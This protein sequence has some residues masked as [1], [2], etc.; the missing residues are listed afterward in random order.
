MNVPR[1]WLVQ[2]LKAWFKAEHGTYTGVEFM[3]GRVL[4]INRPGGQRI[5][6]DIARKK[7]EL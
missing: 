6:V 5:N 2:V 3:S 7:A 1:S 4:H